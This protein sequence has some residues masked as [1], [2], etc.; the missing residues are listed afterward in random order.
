MPLRD[1]QQAAFD[2]AKEYLHG[3]KS[4][5]LI[6]AATGAGK[7]HVIAAIAEWSM[8]ELDGKTLCLAPSKELV[9]QNHAKFL[10]SGFPASIYS[11]SAG[12]KCVRHDVIFGTPKTVQNA[13]DRF[14]R[15][16]LV[17][18][19]EAHGITPTIKS[20]I[21]SL[22]ERNHELRV[23]GLTATPYRTG[24]G[25]IFKVDIDGA[26]VVQI[27]DPYFAKRIYS[28]HARDLIDRGYL[29]PVTSERVEAHYDTS[30]LEQ[31][32]FGR[33]DAKQVEQAF[34]GKGRLTASIVADIVTCSQDRVGVVIFAASIN[35]A[36]EVLE[37]LPPGNEIITGKTPK[38]ERERIIN[39]FKSMRFKYLVNVAVLT[40]GFD[41]PHI[42]VV[43][44]LRPTESPGLMQQIIGRGLR[45]FEGKSDCLLLDYAENIER[46]FPGG[47][48]FD[49]AIK[50]IQSK[51]GAES[52][53]AECP[54]CMAVN[55]FA[56][57]PN[58]D[59]YEIN[60]HGYFVDLRGE[61]IDDEKY[62]PIPAH[63]GR[64]CQGYHLNHDSGELE[65]CDYRWTYKECQEDG[66]GAQNDIAA[67]V[68]NSCGAELVDP[69]EKLR[70]EFARIKADPY[71]TSVNRV[72]S[73]E[74]FKTTSIAGND[75]VRAD[76]I[77][78]VA[79]FSIWYM[80]KRKREWTALSEA[81][82][83]PGHVAPDIETFLGFL[84]KGSIPQT[85]TCYRV[86]ESAWWRVV[87]YNQPEP[88]CPA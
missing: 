4:P 83:G 20:I 49:P 26:P 78:D 55:Q 70:I 76:W 19:D 40:T 23:L 46:H 8:T 38:R 7:S 81:V 30:A 2:A 85:V 47:D 53:P 54:L 36:H 13:L 64:R 80:P 35:H 74:F 61:T 48:V 73:V 34:T 33:F 29:T 57:R 39:S 51:G 82:Y 31:D 15:I 42:D 66:C 52:V 25:Y 62:G 14:P 68:C 41:A 37:S 87:A 5:A 27:K 22:R 11:A 58:D 28:V 1:Y 12:R 24:E 44:I 45:L 32:R 10:A 59:G 50:V 63:F 18:I 9:E 60:K 17:V 86:K 67:R 56:A 16:G 72:I 77:T 3:C 43:A 71:Q 69:N 21:A 79:S 75:T 84:D 6:E 65:Q 88:V